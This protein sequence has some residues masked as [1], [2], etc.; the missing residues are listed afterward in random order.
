MKDKQYERISVEDK[1]GDIQLKNLSAKHITIEEKLGD[2]TLEHIVSKD[3]AIAQSAGDIEVDGQLYGNS[4]VK[5]SM[6]DITIHVR[7]DQKDYR[8]RV[9]NT[10]GDTQIQNREWELSCDAEEGN[11]SSDN[12]LQLHSSMGDI[13]LQFE[14]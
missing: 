10:M 1:L 2:I 5:S 13:D 4:V 3:L 9:K 11:R 14:G 7:G 12:Y 8:Y 6:G